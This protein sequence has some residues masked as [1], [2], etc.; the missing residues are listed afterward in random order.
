MT[1]DL[2]SRLALAC[3]LATAAAAAAALPRPA[4][5]QA[6]P[7]KK[8]LSQA[9]TGQAKAD[10]ESGKLL[11]AD[12]DF[13]GALIKFQ[14]AYDQSKDPRLLWNAAFCQKNLRHYAKVIATL[15]RYLA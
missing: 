15:K 5:A 11:A 4:L 13:A 2:P 1:R 7:T 8:P 14:S 6:P 10:F 12:G 3:V 9:L